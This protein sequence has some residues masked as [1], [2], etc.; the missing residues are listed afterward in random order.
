MSRFDITLSRPSAF[1]REIGVYCKEI[2]SGSGGYGFASSEHYTTINAPINKHVNKRD[3]MP[4]YDGTL[5]THAIIMPPGL[6]PRP[7][8]KPV[9]LWRT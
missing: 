1:S 4:N 5:F 7:D 9:Y 6:L 2:S 8:E 3:R